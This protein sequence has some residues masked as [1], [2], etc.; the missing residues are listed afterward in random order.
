MELTALPDDALVAVMQLLDVRDLLSCRLACRR[1][2][3]LALHPDAWRRRALD[4]FP[5]S[6]RCICP[7]LRLAPCALSMHVEFP[8][9]LWRH[10]D[11]SSAEAITT[12]KCAVNILRVLVDEHCGVLDAKALILQQHSLGR[13]KELRL[14][15]LCNRQ[16]DESLLLRTVASMPSLERLWI[17]TSGKDRKPTPIPTRLRITPSLK[18]FACDSGKNWPFIHRMLSRHAATLETVLVSGLRTP[19]SIV[20]L[21]TGMPNLTSLKCDCSPGIKGILGAASLRE[22]HLV[23][24]SFGGRGAEAADVTAAADGVLEA[25]ELLRRAEHLRAVT[26]EYTPAL[27]CT[28]VFG[29]DLVLALASSGR[30]RL[31]TLCIEDYGG[32]RPSGFPQLQPLVSALP[33][34][35]SLLHLKVAADAD[36]AS[37]LLSAISPASAPALQSVELPLRGRRAHTWLHGDAVK[38]AFSANPSLHIKMRFPLCGDDDCETCELAR[39]H[40]PLSRRS[41]N[42]KSNLGLFSHDPKEKCLQGHSSDRPWVRVPVT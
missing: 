37:E 3:E 39:H 9:S 10:G 33:G 12:S 26:L 30:S 34:L 35:P 17:V 6:V 22:L 13:L 11:T 24:T 42:Q 4:L 20:P 36:I 25:A 38:A 28:E 5:D 19:L 29:A 23:I 14:Y 27:F 41:H 16:Q 8:G 15:L 7:M 40:E 32:V 2:G 18:S 1:L 21:V 31:E